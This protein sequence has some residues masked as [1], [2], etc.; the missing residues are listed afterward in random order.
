MSLASELSICNADPIVAN[1]RGKHR[2]L[3]S[4]ATGL[5]ADVETSVDWLNNAM[6]ARHYRKDFHLRPHSVEVRAAVVV[7]VDAGAGRS[8]HPASFLTLKPRSM[9]MIR[10]G[11]WKRLAGVDPVGWR[12]DSLD[13]LIR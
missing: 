9:S 8:L 3:T 2:R 7:A 5:A 11:A 6:L 10:H 1:A 13:E 4:K 12:C